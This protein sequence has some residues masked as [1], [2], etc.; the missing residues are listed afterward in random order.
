M[1][2]LSGETW[3]RFGIWLVVGLVIYAIYGFRHSRLR[4]GDVID[5]SADGS[6]RALR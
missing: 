1:T 3:W 4:R 2:K 6:A 5:P